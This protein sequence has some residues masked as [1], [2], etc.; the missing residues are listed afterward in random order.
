MSFIAANPKLL[1]DLKALLDVGA[2]TQE[3]YDGQKALLLQTTFTVPGPPSTPTPAAAAEPGDGVSNVER[4][5]TK[6]AEVMSSAFDAM[7][8]GTKRSYSASAKSYEPG[9]PI[10]KAAPTKLPVQDTVMLPDDQPSLWSM[11]VRKT[12]TKKLVYKTGLHKCCDCDFTTSKPGPLAVHRKLKH[13]NASTGRNRPIMSMLRDRSESQR[14][15]ARNVEIAFIVGDIIAAAVKQAKQPKKVDGRK[16][17]GGCGKR[18]QR[19]YEFKKKVILDYERY[20]KQYPELAGLHSTMVGD[21]YDIARGQVTDWAR[22]KESILK[23]AKNIVNRKSSRQR[24]K[25]GRFHELEVKLHVEFK[26]KRSKGQK[27]GPR[28]IKQFMRKEVRKLT[29]IQAKVFKGG[30][31]W[32]RRFCKRWNIVMRRKSNVKRVPI[33]ERIP[34]IKRWFA[35]YRMFL[36]SF[37]GKRGYTK[38]HSIFLPENH[39]S[40]DAVPAGLYNPESTYEQKG[41]TRVHICSNG[42]ADSHRFATLQVLVRN[43]NKPD[44]PRNGQPKLCIYF[45]GKGLRISVEERA[46]Y[47]P[48]VVVQF[49]PKAWYDSAL[50]NK[51]VLDYAIAEIPKSVLKAGQRH[52][53]LG[54]NLAGQTK[55]SNPTF[56][57]LL[58]KHCSATF[59][60]LLA[61]CTD[62]IQ[63]VDAGFGALVKRLAEQV[64]TEWFD[65]DENWA[66]WTASTLSASRRRVLM[67]IW[68]GEAYRR[69]CAS[70]DFCSV[71]NRTGNNLTA[72]GSDDKLIKLQGYDDFSFNLADANRDPLTGELVEASLPVAEAQIEAEETAGLSDNEEQEELSDNDENSCEDGDSSDEGGETSEDGE[73]PPYVCPEEYTVNAEC[74]DNLAGLLIAHRFDMGWYE[75]QCVRQVTMSIRTD[76]NGKYAVKYPDSRRDIMHDLFPED[77]G[78]DK[79]WVIIKPK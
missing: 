4:A 67:T 20:K 9:P 77:Y 72:D 31:G 69:A 52:L 73:G 40:L 42:S 1:L 63:V 50:C 75:G 3:E 59:W 54:D 60:N 47:D 11:G 43:L 44:L 26:L 53:I 7:A 57:K 25:Q 49:Q 32:L 78:M 74:E 27:V 13:A 8:T 18:M 22:A 65:V 16:K 15:R 24:K 64:Q 17:N 37:K 68:Y 41:A 56:A 5:V 48:D 21:M 46:A 19:S 34:K 79:I 76:E 62:E 45:R 12:I 30:Y 70:Y 71:F 39:W 38:K 51:W 58:D 33:A 10:K 66:E 61:G 14:V 29:S 36:I 28:W 35:I 6:L 2:L 55:K 23:Y